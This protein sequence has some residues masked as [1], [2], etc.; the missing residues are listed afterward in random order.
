MGRPMP[1]PDIGEISSGRLGA[2]E[3]MIAARLDRLPILPFHRKLLGLIGAGMFF[4]SFDIYLAGSVLGALLHDGWSTVAT[5]A[6]FISMTFVGMTIGAAA[7]GWL[8]DRYGR[9][10]TYLFNLGIF[11]AAS[12]ACAAAPTIGWLIAGRFVTGLGLGAEIVI[13]Y[14][15]MLEF[16]PPSARGRWAGLLSLITNFGLFASTLLSWLL[17]PDFG[18]RPMFLIAGIGAFVVLWLRKSIPES[19]RW[20]ASQGRMAEAEA[21]VR[22]AEA[23]AGA[24]PPLP[25]V[26]AAAPGQPVGEFIR[27]ALVGSVMQVVVGVAIYGFVVWVPT[28][29]VGHGVSIS[30]SLGQAVFMSFGGPA[31]SALGWLMS[32]RL[33]RRPAIIGASLLAAVCGPAFAHASDQSVAVALGFVMF[34]LIYFLVAVI[35][36]GYVPEL[37]P[38]ATRMRGNAITSVAGRLA[39]MVVPYG[40][41]WLLQRGGVTEVLAAV[42]AA[43]V[44]QALLAVLYRVET[45]GRSLEAIAGEADSG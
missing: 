44:V 18:W 38:T 14:A 30:S 25:P 42:S 34:T 31:G 43:L 11:G 23:G 10:F 15:A 4:D 6:R 36:A 27:R 20:L 28:F 22:M 16:I 13:G 33:G 5:N 32:D 24:L 8:G 1:A 3:M 40:V 2:G 35:V 17:I 37:F 12:L 7:A 39:A 9:R 41:V 45:R 26:A 21:I 19:P 29:L